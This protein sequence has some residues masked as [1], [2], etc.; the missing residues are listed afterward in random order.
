M[1]VATTIKEGEICERHKGGFREFIMTEIF[2]FTIEEDKKF[3]EFLKEDEFAEALAIAWRYGSNRTDRFTIRNIRKEIPDRFQRLLV[4]CGPVN[5]RGRHREDKKDFWEVGISLHHPF[6]KVMKEM[7]WTPIQ[8]KNRIF[9]RGNFNERVFVA[10]YIRLLH[11]LGTIEGKD[12]NRVY[13]RPRL[14]I[15]GSVDVL[16]NISRVLHIELGV[17]VKKLQTDWKIP[18]AKTIYYQSKKEIPLILEFAGAFE[19]LEVFNDLRLGYV[20]TNMVEV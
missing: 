5:F 3:N 1:K 7:G 16:N 15:H 11:D 10:T 4:R 14:R 2:K 8:Q 17:G 9:P 6:F 18:Q 20:E 19:T 12:K 13:K